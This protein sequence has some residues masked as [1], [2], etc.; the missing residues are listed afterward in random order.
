MSKVVTLR[1]NDE[2]YGLFRRFADDDNRPLSNFIETAAKKY[3]E[4]MEFVDEFE[5]KEIRAQ[6]SLNRRLRKGHRDAENK[7]GRF[8]D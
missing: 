8:V 7:K 1:L 3:I 2:T 5:M 4:E 6:V